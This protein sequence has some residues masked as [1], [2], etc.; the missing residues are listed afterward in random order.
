MNDK[1]KIAFLRQRFIYG[2]GSSMPGRVGITTEGRRSIKS[3][4]TK[5]GIKYQNLKIRK[6]IF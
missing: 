6:L 3:M 5:I 2:G 4:V 1:Q